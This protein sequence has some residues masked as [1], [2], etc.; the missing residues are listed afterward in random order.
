MFEAQVQKCK[1]QLPKIANTQGPK[2]QIQRRGKDRLLFNP[3]HLQDE[4]KDTR[5]F[6]LSLILFKVGLN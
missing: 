4:D 6:I 1:Y 2:L 5:S 3:K